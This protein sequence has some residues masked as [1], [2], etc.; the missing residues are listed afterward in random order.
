MQPADPSR[1][2]GS[3]LG[4]L[5]RGPHD[6]AAWD[7]FVC[8]YGPRILQWCRSWN[9][10][11]A[12]ADD[13]CQNVL[14]A[15]ARQ[16]A[17]FRYDPSKSFRAWLKTIARAAWCDWLEAM[18]R[19]GRGDGG[20][21][22]RLLESEVARDDL[23]ARLE[24]QFDAELLELAIGQV[25]LRVEPRTWE[26]FRLT[27]FEGVAGAEAAERLGMK[28]ATVFVAKS[29]VRKM[30]QEAIQQLEETP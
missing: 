8:R 6:A 18:R 25:R 24:E 3:L 22:Y 17:N 26:A 21:A 20:D 16:M 7:E 10:Q 19:P 15:V 5:A 14:L 30:L 4:R 1:T 2:S 12:D 23:A 9:L 29:K 28:V 13:V 11:P 27:A